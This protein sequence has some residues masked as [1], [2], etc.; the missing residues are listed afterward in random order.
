MKLHLQLL[1]KRILKAFFVLCCLDLFNHLFLALNFI[2][3]FL[4]L[5]L[6]LYYI[7][8]GE[9]IVLRFICALLV[10]L[11]DQVKCVIDCLNIVAWEDPRSISLIEERDSWLWLRNFLLFKFGKYFSCMCKHLILFRRRTLLFIAFFHH[12]KVWNQNL[13]YVIF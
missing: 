6:A 3:E 4:T 8:C 10:R 2:L 12:I 5:I 7:T 13:R 1:H 9:L 11:L